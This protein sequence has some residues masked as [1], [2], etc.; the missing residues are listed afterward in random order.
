MHSLQQGRISDCTCLKQDTF[1]HITLIAFKL[2]SMFWSY[3]DTFSPT[4]VNLGSRRIFNFCYKASITQITNICKAIEGTSTFWNIT[5]TRLHF[6]ILLLHVYILEY[7]Y[8]NVSLIY[9]RYQKLPQVHLVN[10]CSIS[11]A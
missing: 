8:Y 1:N 7:Y 9:L 3:W 6:G 11:L 4:E 5:T 2:L 10:W